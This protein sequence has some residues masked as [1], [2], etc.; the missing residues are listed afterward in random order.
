VYENR[1]SAIL[2]NLLSSQPHRTAWLLPANVC[3][4]VPLTFR[5][6]R[7]SFEFVDIEDS[8]LCMSRSEVLK[9]L[10]A[11]P[12]RYGGVLFVRS[13]GVE[14][15]S[16]DLFYEIKRRSP[17]T[18]LIDDRCLCPPRLDEPASPVADGMLYSTGYAKPV[19]LGFGGFAWLAD[20]IAY[21]RHGLRYRAEEL[22]RLTSLI[23]SAIEHGRRFEYTD[24]HWLDAREPVMAL[25]EYRST[26]RAHALESV[27]L[28]STINSIYRNGLPDSICLD[29]RFQNWRF[30]I[31]VPEKDRLLAALF[32]NGLFA[33]SHY[34]DLTGIFSNGVS[35]EA[36]RLH[37]RVVN[38]FNDRYFS[39]DQ[40]EQT[41][42]LVLEHLAG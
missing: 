15:A 40:A 8:T 18:L 12:D 3:P 38:L 10:R 41:V 37:R 27:A 2:H 4:I 19:D 7:C 9:R 11:A 23:K 5:K 6:A 26:I 17:A 42:A 34:A 32:D 21:R 35:P 22:E 31:L 33:S 39:E 14:D 25:D 30:Q 36:A 28:K 13:Y 29:E 24:T 16:D 20:G 1:A